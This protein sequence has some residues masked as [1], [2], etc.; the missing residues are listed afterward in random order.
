MSARRPL[1]DLGVYPVSDPSARIGVEAACVAAARGGARLVQLRDK[2]ASDEELTALAR[3]L[4][5]ALTPLGC[6][7]LVNDRVGVAKAAGAAGAHVGQSDAAVAEARALL[8]E[9]AILGLSVEAPGH[10][11]RDDWARLDYVGAGPVFATATKPDH[12]E[13]LGWDGLARLCAL[14][15]VPAVAIGGVKTAHAGRARGAGA[16]G[17]AMVS[18]IFGSAD[19]EAATRA[20]VAAWRDAGGP[21]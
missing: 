20:A 6:A 11:A 1:P 5:A 8:G 9:D 2:T 3:R 13:P 21:P 18:E 4:V 12:A 19:P 16:A 14:A 10:L 17:L 7:L 15:P